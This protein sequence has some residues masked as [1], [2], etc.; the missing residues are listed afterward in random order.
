MTT[1]EK[2]TMPGQGEPV[3]SSRAYPP[4]SANYLQKKGNSA[5]VEKTNNYPKLQYKTSPLPA[6]KETP[7][8]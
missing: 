1:S 8:M 3:L 5:H 4:L 2:V 6:V 7:Q